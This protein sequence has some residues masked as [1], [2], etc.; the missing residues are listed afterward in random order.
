MSA[1]LWER[2][3]FFRIPISG[4]VLLQQGERVDG[5]YCLENLSIGGCMLSRG[6]ECSLGDKVDL[7]LHVD[8]E[9]EIELPAKVVR[10]ERAGAGAT[11]GLCFTDTDPKFEDRIQDLVMRSIERDQ[12]SEILL[13]HAHPERVTPLLDTIRD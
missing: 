10:H 13:V 7:T 4:K 12:Q 1:M 3:K 5:L 8:G 9:D 2:R 6:P 11:I